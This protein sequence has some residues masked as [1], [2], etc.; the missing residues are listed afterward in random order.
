M[1]IF[2]F[3][4]SSTNGSRSDLPEGVN[5]PVRDRRQ[6]SEGFIIYFTHFERTEGEE[7]PL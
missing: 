6:L 1:V 4:F 2:S 7:F 3:R 5:K